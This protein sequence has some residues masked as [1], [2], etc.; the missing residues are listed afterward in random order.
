MCR[1]L[2]TNQ[3]TT[4]DTKVH[5]GKSGWFTRIAEKNRILTT[6]GTEFH[7]GCEQ[8]TEPQ[9]TRRFTKEKRAGLHRSRRKTESLPEGTEFHRG[10]EQITEPQ[11]TRRFTKEN[12]AGLH[13]SRRKTESLPQGTEFHRGC[14]GGVR[15][16][17]E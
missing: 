6:G 5:K 1:W 4:K 11:R 2:R 14:P 13:R 7:R 16:E 12:R 15:R 9:R 3:C 8:I 17:Y 10:C